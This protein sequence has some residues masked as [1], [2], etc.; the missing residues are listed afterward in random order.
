MNI[1]WPEIKF[2]CVHIAPWGTYWRMKHPHPETVLDGS[3]VQ[4][5]ILARNETEALAEFQRYINKWKWAA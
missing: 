4:I 5:D 2:W 3:F 1:I